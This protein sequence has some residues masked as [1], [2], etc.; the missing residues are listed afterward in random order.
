MYK[1]VSHNSDAKV[2]RILIKGIA[3]FNLKGFANFNPKGI[4]D[5]NSCKKRRVQKLSFGVYLNV[6]ELHHQRL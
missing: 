2:S 3:N 1:K 5:F 6:L 4:A